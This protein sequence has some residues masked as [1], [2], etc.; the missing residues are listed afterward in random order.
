[1][2]CD[3]SHQNLLLILPHSLADTTALVC[4]LSLFLQSLQTRLL[5]G[6]HRCDSCVA[7]SQVLGLLATV[8]EELNAAQDKFEAYVQEGGL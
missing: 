8:A 3:D 4:E 1:M 6:Y 5:V 7:R 2:C